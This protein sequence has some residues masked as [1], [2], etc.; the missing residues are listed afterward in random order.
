MV[1]LE[2]L[3]DV[4]PP[5]TPT[6][7]NTIMTVR[8]IRTSFFIVIGFLYLS[9]FQLLKRCIVFKCGLYP[10]RKVTKKMIIVKKSFN[11]GTVSSNKKRNFL[12]EKRG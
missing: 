3:H 10:K 1:S 12:R 9:K 5:Q 11:G 8:N 7:A 2:D 6:I 4:T